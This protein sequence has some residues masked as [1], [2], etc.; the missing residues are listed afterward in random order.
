MEVTFYNFIY[1]CRPADRPVHVVG[2]CWVEVILW[3]L[4]CSV[5]NVWDKTLLYKRFSVS[6]TYWFFSLSDSWT[7]PEWRWFRKQNLWKHTFL[8]FTFSLILGPIA[9]PGRSDLVSGCL[10]WS[11]DVAGG[12]ASWRPST[13]LSGVAWNFCGAVRLGPCH[14]GKMGHWGNVECSLSFELPALYMCRG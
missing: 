1:F 10:C 9:H 5:F 12:L 14:S 6:A 7:P 2:M 13:L 8:F 3:F 11:T 4:F